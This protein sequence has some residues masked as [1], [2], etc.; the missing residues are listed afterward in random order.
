MQGNI[1]SYNQKQF[2]GLESFIIN[3]YLFIY[4]F[5]KITDIDLYGAGGTYY[6]YQ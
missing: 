2:F 1:T 5:M 6:L 4:Y 3:Y